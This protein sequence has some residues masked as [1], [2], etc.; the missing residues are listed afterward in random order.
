L[1]K[2]ATGSQSRRQRNRVGRRYR[3]GN[4]SH[5]NDRAW[6]LVFAHWAWHYFLLARIERPER[7]G[8]SFFV[9]QINDILS[10]IVSFIFLVDFVVPDALYAFCFYEEGN[11]EIEANCVPDVAEPVGDFYEEEHCVEQ[12][13]CES[14]KDDHNYEDVGL[15]H[16]K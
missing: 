2:G 3:C 16:G 6:P 5:L 9:H 1:H 13:N 8:S 7:H 4:V 12:L 15:S 10:V 14:A 11:A